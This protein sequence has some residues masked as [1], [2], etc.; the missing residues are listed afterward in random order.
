MGSLSHFIAIPGPA[1]RGYLVFEWMMLFAFQVIRE[2]VRISQKELLCRKMLR[3]MTDE[4]I[5]HKGMDG[6][7]FYFLLLFLTSVS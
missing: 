5:P 4:K 3:G 6:H 2:E 7:R 1:A